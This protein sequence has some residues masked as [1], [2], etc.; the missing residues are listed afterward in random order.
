MSILSRISARAGHGLIATL[1]APLVSA[2]VSIA[3]AGAISPALADGPD[4]VAAGGRCAALA[5][6]ELK[7]VDVTSAVVQAANAPV[8]GAHFPSMTGGYGEG[9]QVAGLPA[10]CR[11]SGSIHPT[12]DSA[13]GFEVWLPEDNWD[14][15]F[16][17]ANNGG[18]AGSINYLDLAFGVMGGK[19]AA[20]TDTGHRAHAGSGDWAQGHPEKVRDYGW[21]AIH[22]TTVA[23]KDLIAAYYGREAAYSYFI[24]CSNGGRQ[25]LMEASRFP[26]DYDG[27][28]AGAPF[29]GTRSILSF[30]NVI[31]AQLPEGAALHPEQAAVLQAAVLEQCDALDGQ[32][33][34]LVEDP[35]QCGFDASVLACGDTDSP[36]CF[37]APQLAA[38]AQLHAGYRDDD[39]RVIAYGL[40]PTGAEVGV[41][42]AQFGWEGNAL[43]QFEPDSDNTNLADEV[44]T[45]FTSPPLSSSSTLDFDRDPARLAAA[46]GGD[47]NPQPDLTAFFERGGKLILW[48][49]WADAILPPE[50]TIDLHRQILDQSGPLAQR[51][52]QF[53]MVPGVQ[54]CAGGPGPDTFGQIGAPL[55]TQAPESSIGAA[56]LAWVETGREPRTLTGTRSGGMG[57]A[58][59][60]GAGKERLICAYPDRA[61]LMAGADADKASSYSCQAP[62]EPK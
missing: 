56:L 61:V 3:G 9:P 41:P 51:Q 48:H 53:F 33:D 55:P 10:F 23:A 18:L 40:P 46:L 17:G 60:S 28:I 5:E 29:Q 30:A 43:V 4:K 42:V 1:A 45:N 32:R 26:D 11:V 54:H 50:A 19:A 36:G 13:I 6:L 8:A 16:V 21:R 20:S 35:L 14:G 62:G 15:R 59:Q 22:L 34:G 7:D 25:A 39:G 31:Q 57:M 52:M 58:P 2:L 12:A 24:G 37:S 47:L 44:L 27:I 38:L 49:G